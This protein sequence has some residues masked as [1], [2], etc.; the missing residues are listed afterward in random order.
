MRGLV[1]A[2]MRR[3]DGDALRYWRKRRGL[4]LKRL[5]QES[6]VSYATIS[7]IETG[8]VSEPHDDTMQKLAD[9]LELD[10][11]ELW[12]YGNPPSK[13]PDENSEVA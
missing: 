3:A 9:A 5:Y 8:V 13:A 7:R 12:I 1:M 11:D 2:V 4:T 10:V 6:G